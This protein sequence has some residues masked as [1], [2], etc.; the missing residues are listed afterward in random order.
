MAKDWVRS[1]GEELDL[2]PLT[3]LR[4]GPATGYAELDSRIKA[5]KTKT[6]LH[7]ATFVAASLE[8][9]QQESDNDALVAQMRATCCHSLSA[10]IH[11]WHCGGAPHLTAGEAEASWFPNETC[12]VVRW[13]SM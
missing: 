1:K 6:L 10:V 9:Q 4:L 2:R 12:F 7:Y 8:S 3:R 5:A 13:N 11:L